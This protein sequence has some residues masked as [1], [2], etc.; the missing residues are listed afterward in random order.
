LPFSRSYTVKI[1]FSYF[2]YQ[3]ILPDQCRIRNSPHKHYLQQVAKSVLYKSGNRGAF[4]LQNN[5]CIIYT[6]GTVYLHYALLSMEFSVIVQRCLF[7][8]SYRES[9]WRLPA[10]RWF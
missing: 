10:L 9:S 5:F 6:A 8:I 7:M 1:T 4:T 3:V 2:L